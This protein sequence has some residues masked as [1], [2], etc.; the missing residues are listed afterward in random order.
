MSDKRHHP[1]QPPRPTNVDGKL[2]HVGIE[3]EFAAL[4][5]RDVA[6]KLQS[7]FGGDIRQIDPHLFRVSGTTLGD[8]V[9]ELDTQFAHRPDKGG[10]A[11][12]GPATEPFDV[13]ADQLRELYGDI[14][15]LIVPCEIVAPPLEIDDLAEFDAFVAD[16]TQAGAAGTAS[17]PFYAFG[18]HLNPD[19]ATDDVQ[20]ITAVLKAELLLSDW[21]REIMA[22]DLTRRLTAFVD[23]FPE[24]YVLKVVAADYWPDLAGLIDDYLAFNATRDRELDM[25][26]L[27][28]WFD[29]ATV[30]R[31]TS[32]VKVG[33]RPTF[34]YRLP[35][36][37][38]GVAGWSLGLEWNR[39]CVIERLADDR[40]KLNAMGSAYIENRRRLIPERWGLRASEWLLV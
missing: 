16:L 9:A 1:K 29:E 30:A 21:M 14:S 3:L 10:P 2:R 28:A 24:A 38:L 26:P 4:S 15:S 25:L 31:A 18:T 8:F 34:H 39:W 36:A 17:S 40:D 22:I 12:D 11:V 6:L 32:G 20:W 37:N 27:F 19:I 23:P 35:N 33:K 13:I 7:R 5:A